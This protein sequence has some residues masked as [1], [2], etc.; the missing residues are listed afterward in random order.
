MAGFSNRWVWRC[1]DEHITALYDRHVTEAHLEV[2]RNLRDALGRQPGSLGSIAATHVLHRVPGTIGEKAEILEC[3]STLLRPG[4][5]LFGTT[6]LA[7]GV[8]Q[9][10]LS[11]AHIA[12][13]NRQGVFANRCDHL[14][15]LQD[16]LEARFADYELS[17]RG[18]V[19]IFA[20]RA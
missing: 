14:E 6:V 16:E 4:G 1:R 2:G 10:W 15:G 17:T 8:P 3:L 5:V 12:G 7:G 9:T 11:R 18:S 20:I 13:L 19:A